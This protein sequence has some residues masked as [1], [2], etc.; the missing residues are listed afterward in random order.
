MVPRGFN[1]D[2]GDFADSPGKRCAVDTEM[3]R[4]VVVHEPQRTS[5][6][7]NGTPAAIR[8]VYAAAAY[9]LEVHRRISVSVGVG[10][11]VVV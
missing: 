5:R 10:L 7:L 11:G 3:A 1:A 9:R 4:S 6:C 8:L 2:V